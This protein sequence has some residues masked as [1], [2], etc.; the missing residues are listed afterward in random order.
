MIF[1]GA[2]TQGG[3]VSVSFPHGPQ[4]TSLDV[5]G[6]SIMSREHHGLVT[7]AGYQLTA[8]GLSSFLFSEYPSVSCAPWGRA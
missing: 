3:L 4:V 6:A 8:A 1:V 7:S 5:G 2:Q